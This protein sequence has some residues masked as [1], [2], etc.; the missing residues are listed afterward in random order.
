MNEEIHAAHVPEE[1]VVSLLP[2]L[3]SSVKT[4]PEDEGE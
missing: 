4:L 1:D 2:T 3:L